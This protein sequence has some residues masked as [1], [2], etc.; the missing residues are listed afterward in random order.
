MKD[1]TQKELEAA[2]MIVQHI[3]VSSMCNT[4]VSL[5]LVE[6]AI[7]KHPEYFPEEVKHKDALLNASTSTE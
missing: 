7:K 2:P 4:G 5:S 6:E 1:L 3:Y